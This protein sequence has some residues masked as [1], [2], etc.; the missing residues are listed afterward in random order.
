MLI[1]QRLEGAFRVDKLRSIANWT[2]LLQEQIQWLSEYICWKVQ[3]GPNNIQPPHNINHHGCSLNADYKKEKKEKKKTELQL[4][5]IRQKI[6]EAFV[7]TRY[8]L[9]N[10]VTTWQMPS[11]NLFLFWRFVVQELLKWTKTLQTTLT[12][13][14]AH[15]NTGSK[16]ILF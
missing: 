2:V 1:S 3:W 9:A 16:S 10:V 12:K 15:S 6:S 4:I 13:R 5:H 8:S 7:R 11:D 14:A